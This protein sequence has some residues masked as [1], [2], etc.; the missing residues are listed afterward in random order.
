VKYRRQQNLERR[1]KELKSEEFE[2][3]EQ[4]IM[5]LYGL[6]IAQAMASTVIDP[7]YWRVDNARFPD[8]RRVHFEEKMDIY[9]PLDERGAQASSDSHH[10]QIIWLVDKESYESCTLNEATSRRIMTCDVPHREKKFTVKFQ[11]VSPSPFGLEFDEGAY[12]IISTSIGQ[13]RSEEQITNRRH[14]VCQTHGMRMKLE[15]TQGVERGLEPKDDQTEDTHT[16]ASETTTS[17]EDYTPYTD[18]ELI[19]GEAVSEKSTATIST[20]IIVGVVFFVFIM[21]LI[22]IAFILFRR[23][24]QKAKSSAFNPSTMSDYTI[25]K[26]GRYQDS[27]QDHQYADHLVPTAAVAGSPLP[28][29]FIGQPAEYG[30][31]IVTLYPKHPAE[32]GLATS[33]VASDFTYRPYP[34]PQQ[35]KATLSSN[36][37]RLSE[38]SDATVLV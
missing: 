16:K 11:K 8:V 1:N 37:E 36:G 22:V 35:Q 27:Y 20:A 9:C 21:F 31:K 12:Y 15:V 25:G 34:V 24:S 19:E 29:P 5:W 17:D 32:H 33:Q 3:Q 38:R 14:G 26:N 23:T 30:P 6:L 18:A 10:F 28:H 4:R 13:N 2:K 7:V